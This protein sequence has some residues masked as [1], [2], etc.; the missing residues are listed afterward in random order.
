MTIS[1]KKQYPKVSKTIGLNET[2][3]KIIGI[4]TK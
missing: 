4:L 2:E 3:R 1:N